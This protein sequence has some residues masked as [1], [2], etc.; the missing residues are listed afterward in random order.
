MKESR[1]LEYKE[2]ITNTFLKTVSAFANYDGGEIWF[3]ITDEE[4]V[5]GISDPEQ[6]C[7]DIENRINDSISPQPDYELAIKEDHTIYLKV[8]PGKCQPYLY[9][10]KAY[11][12]NDTATVEVD[13]T[14]LTR[15]ILR[16]SNRSYEELP[17]DNQEPV[18][19]KLEKE[20]K[21]VTGIDR[22]DLNVLKTLNLYSDK[23]GYNIAAE[24]LADENPF[25]GVDIGKFGDSISI[26]QKRRTYE[27]ISALS[28]YDAAY[29]MFRDY[30]E[31]ELIEGAQRKTVHLI[32][33]EAYREAV[34]NALIHRV[35]DVKD[36]IRIFMFDDRVEIFSPGGL[37]EGI[38]R[39]AY[40]AGN[41]S[42]LRNPILSN[43]FFRLR[44]V[45]IFGTGIR[46]IKEA[47]MD[48]ITKPEFEIY[49]DSIKV[50]L[51]VVKARN[52]LK[53]EMSLVYEAVSGSDGCSIRQIEE[54]VPYGKTKV[55]KILNE[56]LSR[57][58]IRVTG[59]GRG[60]KYHTLS[61]TPGEV[62]T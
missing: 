49:D 39:D 41:Y 12:R 3:G 13:H 46:R 7:L 14:E 36:H 48:S 29:E 42:T 28:L 15:L 31:Y 19:A 50:V 56:L 52:A 33:E 61:E 45:E 53:G 24:I 20:M 11:K 2:M 43:V 32:P 4:T 25:P 47:Y 40:L 23:D 26:I 1:H 21:A 58:L 6:Q 51:P 37:P 57:N 16:G 59:Q 5:V 8:L 38:S 44:I 62:S 55:R 30:Y 9:K 17:S 27:H 22:L 54:Q 60:T 34:A 35:W 10:S 18:F